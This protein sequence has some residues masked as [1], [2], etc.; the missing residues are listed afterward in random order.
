MEQTDT[1]STSISWKCKHTWRRASVNTL[2]CLLG[3]S[4]G[5]FGTIYFF[6]VT[7]NPWSFSVMSIMIL[8]IINGLITS[9]MLETFILSR[10]MVLR[11]AFKTAI[12]MSMISMISMEIAMN[13]VDVLITGGAVLVWWVL[14]IML[15][16]GFITPL[17]YN[18]YRLKKFG[19]ACH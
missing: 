2:W 15:L 4:I 14:P 13:V 3:C 11:L 17:P 9:I 5:D 6:Q 19:Q 18:Y 1:L 16:A 10:Q 7:Q 8:A 12:G